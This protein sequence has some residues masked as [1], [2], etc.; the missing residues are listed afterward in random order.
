MDERDDKHRINPIRWVPSVYFGMGLPFVMLALVSSIM[1]TKLKV[2][3]QDITFWATLIT[4]PWSLKWL[5]SPIMESFGTKRGYIIFTELITALLFISI[6]FVL[7]L[8]GELSL[9][10]SLPEISLPSALANL[11][12]W[13]TIGGTLVDSTLPKFYVASIAI[14]AMVALSG[15]THDIAGDGVYMEQ[16]DTKT[17]S[18][19]SG[20]QGAFYNIAKVL[21]N[22]GLVALSG[23]LTDSY[24]PTI[25]WSIIMAICGVLML[26]LSIYH[27]FSLPRDAKVPESRTFGERIQELKSIVSSFFGKK[28]IWL[29]LLFILLYRL[30]EGLAMKIAPIFL[31]DARTKGGV[32][33]TELEFGL[34]VGTAGSIAFILGSILA[35]YYISRRGLKRSLLFLVV[36]FNLP[37]VVYLL[38]ALYQPESLWLIGSGIV[39]EYFGYG[40]GF[41]GI[42]LFMMQQIAPGKYQMAHYA[43]AN[44]LMNLSVM[45]PGMMSGYLS[46]SLGY[47]TF[48]TVVM[49]A[50][51]PVVLMSLVLPFAHDQGGK[52]TA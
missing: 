18:V 16:L 47:T 14:M 26:G 36:A 46:T 52:P 42:T 49:V 27:Y 21:A 19:Y 4:L 28:F 51:I 34:I 31:V 12:G 30:A 17:Q 23:V 5:I 8:P 37:F 29:Y 10:I 32:G 15:S 11:L 48:F 22:G 35:G 43:F 3:A 13:E 25:A 20:W 6:C 44:S 33:L 24:G 40:F 41:V 50:A 9:R 38:L 7:P 45:I 2:S 1:F 39:V